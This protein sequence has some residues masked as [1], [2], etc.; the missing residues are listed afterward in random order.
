MKGWSFGHGWRTPPRHHTEGRPARLWVSHSPACDDWIHLVKN[1]PNCSSV[2]SRSRLILCLQRLH[3][4]PSLSAWKASRF[5][6][7]KTLSLGSFCCLALAFR[8]RNTAFILMD[9]LF[10]QNIYGSNPIID[11]WLS[12]TWLPCYRVNYSSAQ[13]GLLKLYSKWINSRIYIQA[14]DSVLCPYSFCCCNK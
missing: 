6:S 9:K 8:C 14:H 1:K 5:T 13:W 12:S 2:L 10:L 4:F 11:L 7:L 3:G